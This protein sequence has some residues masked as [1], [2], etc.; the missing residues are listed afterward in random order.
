MD[1]TTWARAVDLP[2]LAYADW[3]N[4]KD[5]LHLFLQING[6]VRLKAH[7][8]LNHWWHVTLYPAARGLTTGRIPYRDS[9]FEIVYDVIDHEVRVSGEDG[10]RAAFAVSAKTVADFHAAL[11][12]ALAALGIEVRIVAVPYENKSTT[13]F[14]EDR[15]RRAYDPDAVHRYWQVLSAT[16]SI[17]ETYR[18]RFA[19][20]QTPVHLFWH[21]FDLTVTRFSGKAHPLTGGRRSDREAYSHEVVSIGF[22]PGDDAFPEAAYYGYAYPEPPGLK[23]VPLGPA[24]ASWADRN[25]SAIGVYCYEDLRRADDPGAALLAFLEAVYRGAGAKAGRPLA[26][27][28]HAYAEA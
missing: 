3:A 25:E 22:W 12:D 4:T 11:F 19:G 6:K 26:A 28:E 7:P 9:G 5:T 14:A 24:E 21:S 8:K 13:P 23:D 2:P 10:Q 27:F 1:T 17:F 15:A 18:G 16:A 20:K